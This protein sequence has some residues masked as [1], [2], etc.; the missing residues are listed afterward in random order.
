[1]AERGPARRGRDRSTRL[2]GLLRLSHHREPPQDRHFRFRPRARGEHP[3][4]HSA[5]WAALQ[6]VTARRADAI[7]FGSHATLFSFVI[8]P[9]YALYQHAETLLVFQAVMIGA[10]AVPLFL[11][12]RRHV[13]DWVATAL[14]LAYLMS[15][16]VQGSNLYDFSLSA[17]RPLLRLA[18]AVRARSTQERPRRRRARAHALHP[19]RHF[20]GSGHRRALP[21]LLAAPRCRPACSWQ[22]WARRTSS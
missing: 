11:F 12:A 21:P 20:G 10:A 15:P 1:M 14:A 7:H 17:A 3:L 9:F 5:R 16:A 19:R 6:V 22:Q 18:R 4:E 2:R 13:S 8:V